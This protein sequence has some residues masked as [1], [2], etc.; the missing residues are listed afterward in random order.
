MGLPTCRKAH[1]RV[2]LFENIVSDV[3]PHRLSDF[4]S[5]KNEQLTKA[6]AKRKGLLSRCENS[7]LEFTVLFWDSKAL[8]Y[9]ITGLFNMKDG[10]F[11]MQEGL[12]GINA[13]VFS[14]GDGL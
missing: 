13:G 12:F 4:P 3:A 6:G 1:R 14:I 7:F 9:H 11:K 2:S 8:A 5:E 10:L